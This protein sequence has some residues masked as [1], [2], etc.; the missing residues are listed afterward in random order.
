MKTSCWLF[1]AGLIALP[2]SAARVRDINK[3]P[4]VIVVR[5][6]EPTVTLDEKD[7]ESRVILKMMQKQCGVKNLI[8]DPQVPETKGTFLFKKVPCSSAFKVVL[9]SL[10]L[11]SVTYSNSLI[12]VT[13]PK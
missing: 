6:A 2:A 5:P 13:P 4:K 7:V 10:G 9:R 12:N 1:V 3:D 11:S 8:V